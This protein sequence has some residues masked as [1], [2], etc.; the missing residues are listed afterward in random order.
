MKNDEA[1]ERHLNGDLDGVELGAYLSSLEGSPELLREL[2][3][4]ALEETLL[5]EVVREGRV[6]AK[7]RRRMEWPAAAAA[8]LM[9]ALL[10]GILVQ[11]RK[12]PAVPAKTA[13]QVRVDEA[14]RRACRYLEQRRGEFFVAIADG[15]RHSAP[16]RRLYAEL[17]ALT[18]L[19]AGYSESHPLVEECLGRA[20]GRPLESTYVA[21]LQ[22]RL[23]RPELCRRVAQFL[24]DTQCANGQWDYGRAVTI[25][26]P[27][28]E[29]RI[30]RRGNGPASGDNSVTAYAVQGLLACRRAGVDVEPDILVRA[31]RWWLSCQNADGG[32]GYAGGEKEMT[33]TADNPS[34]SSYGSATSFGVASLAALLE[35]IG[36][37]AA[38]D[39]AIARG[40][41]WLG[42]H[43]AV[44]ANPG[45]ASGFSHVHWLS[46]TCRAGT[47]LHQSRFGTHDWYAEGSAFLLSAQQADGAWRLEQGPFM[48][49]EKNDVIDTCLAVLFLLRD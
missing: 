39:A 44:E 13:E 36:P 30:V 5:A 34:V 6:A 31:R 23:G 21:A 38:S 45:K 20:L 43:F 1:L 40:T 42:S 27:P 10:G 8:A 2:T 17:A 22:A 14:V 3:S 37:D 12:P 24:A 7:P 9:L 19:R 48:R 25:L 26:G 11:L 49:G 33:E 15:K 16:P 4:R 32:W 46:G 28:P 47:L 18:L 29:G 35:L 41:A